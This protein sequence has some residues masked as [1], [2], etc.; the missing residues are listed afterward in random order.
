MQQDDEKFRLYRQQKPLKNENVGGS[1]SCCLCFEM[2]FKFFFLKLFYFSTSIKM[3]DFGLGKN[4]NFI[5]IRN[6]KDR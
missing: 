4:I 6:I 3:C 5:T 1:E 2:F